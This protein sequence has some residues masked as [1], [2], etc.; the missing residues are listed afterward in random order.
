MDRIDQFHKHTVARTVTGDRNCVDNIED[1]TLE[2][3]LL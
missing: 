3:L 1:F 2:L